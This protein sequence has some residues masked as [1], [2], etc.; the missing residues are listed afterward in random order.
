MTQAWE[1][2]GSLE[3]SV[4]QLRDALQ[5]RVGHGAAQQVRVGAAAGS[6]RLRERTTA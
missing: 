5:A 2:Y 6:R 1:E 4:E 3:A